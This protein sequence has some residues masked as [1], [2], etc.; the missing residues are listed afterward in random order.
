MP[1][2][3]TTQ[4]ESDEL[5]ALAA[6]CDESA[7]RLGADVQDLY[8]RILAIRVKNDGRGPSGAVLLNAL[9]RSVARHFGNTPILRMARG[10]HPAHGS[11]VE[12]LRLWLPALSAPEKQK[13]AA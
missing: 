12:Q 3:T 13:D 11:F 1:K 5:L 8:N 2:Q 10:V 6:R 7:S 9:Q 4:N